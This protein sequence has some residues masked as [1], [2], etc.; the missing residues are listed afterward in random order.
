MLSQKISFYIHSERCWRYYVLCLQQ[1]QKS[2]SFQACRTIITASTMIIAIFFEKKIVTQM[3]SAK[4]LI[5]YLK[6]AKERPHS[7]YKLLRRHPTAAN[8]M[9]WCGQHDQYY[10]S[11]LYFSCMT[12]T[13]ITLIKV[14]LRVC[15][16]S[17]QL[18]VSSLRLLP[19]HDACLYS[20]SLSII[21]LFVKAWPNSIKQIQTNGKLFPLHEALWNSTPSLN[22]I[23]ILVHPWPESIQLPVM[24][25][26]FPFNTLHWACLQDV[27]LSIIKYMVEQWPKAA[28]MQSILF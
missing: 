13:P 21:Q 22:S 17:V 16:D 15:P 23:R 25:Q 12:N 24:G 18:L 10:R 27:S 7:F 6:P 19:L 3:L 26:H 20:T 9:I 5:C 8:Q 4:L 14:F 1:Q 2:I 28:W 11:P